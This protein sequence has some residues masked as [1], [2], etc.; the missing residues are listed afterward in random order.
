VSNNQNA[1]RDSRFGVAIDKTRCRRVATRR[2]K[3]AANYLGFI[4]L[5]WIR[6][7]R[8]IDATPPPV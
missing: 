6:P 4:R 2:D 5:A 3:L 8:R 1:D 7:W